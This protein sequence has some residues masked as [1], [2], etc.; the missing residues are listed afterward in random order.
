L[1]AHAAYIDPDTERHEH[2]ADSKNSRFEPG[3]PS[4][5]LG[6]DFILDMTGEGKIRTKM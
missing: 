3:N 1:I 4:T 6:F 2:H 5:H